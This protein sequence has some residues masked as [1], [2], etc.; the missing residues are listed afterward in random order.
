MNCPYCGEQQIS[1]NSE[2][3]VIYCPD[4]GCRWSR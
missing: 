3:D 4:C 2:G 1:A